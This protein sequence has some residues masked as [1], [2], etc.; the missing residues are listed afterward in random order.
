M[1]LVKSGDNR[2]FTTIF[3]RHG[4][5]LLGY[6]QRLLGDRERAEDVSQEVWMRIIRDAGAYQGQGH[7]IAWA[8]TITRNTAFNQLRRD[9]DWAVESL[10][11]HLPTAE[12]TTDQGDELRKSIEKKQDIEK[13][14]GLIDLLPS[15]QRAVLVMFLA[16]EMSYEEISVELSTS[17][18]SI[19]SLLFRARKNIQKNWGNQ[20]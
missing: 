14:K 10:D 6:S 4:G 8:Y 20:Q 9:K 12:T 1:E 11:E 19:K 13:L 2:A 17:I 18:S 16:D 15:G 3:D 5:R 7:F